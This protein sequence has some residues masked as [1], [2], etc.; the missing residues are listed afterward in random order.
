MCPSNYNHF[1]DRARYWSKI[2]IFHTPIA[3]DALVKG[4]STSCR[5]IA[6]SFG[7]E[8]LE[9]CRYQMVKKFRRYL[10]SFWRNSRT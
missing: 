1:S 7:M 9:W 4:G 8:K 5:N 10:Y 3:F 2:V 6:I